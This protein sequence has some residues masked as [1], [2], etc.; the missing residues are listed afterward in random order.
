HYQESTGAEP[1]R[2]AAAGWLANRI[3][4]VTSD[5]TVVAGGAQSALFAICDTLLDHGD[6][7]ATGALT[8]PGLK[9]VAIQKGLVL[10]PLESGE[11]GILPDARGRHRRKEPPKAI[12][13]VPSIDT[14]TTGT[15]P[16]QRRCAL[17]DSALK[18]G[19]II[20]EDDP[21]AALRAAQTVSIA[22]RAP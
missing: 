16:E 17:L 20:V 8:Y 18:H 22:E 14:P 6:T 3:H 4:G 21:Y 15:L 5:R 10:A 11:Q 12:Y 1:D 13:V 7:I 19:I 9:A 2:Q